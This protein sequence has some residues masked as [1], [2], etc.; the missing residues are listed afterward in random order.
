MSRL[1]KSPMALALALSAALA[2]LGAGAAQEPAAAERLSIVYASP[3]FQDRFQLYAPNFVERGMVLFN[4]KIRNVT[5]QQRSVEYRMDWYD[6]DQLSMPGVTGWQNL[7]LGPG[8][9][10]D[11][12]AASQQPGAVT[13]RITLREP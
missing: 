7:N 10:V 13:A 3:D 6:Q 9:E 12:R 8:Q 4:M 1:Q 2:F 11:I 5:E